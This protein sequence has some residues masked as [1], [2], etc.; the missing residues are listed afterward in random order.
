MDR[1][2]ALQ[3]GGG[4]ATVLR[5]RAGQCGR[6]HVDHDAGPVGIDVRR[7]V[8][9]GEPGERVGEMALVRLGR[10]GG[11]VLTELAGDALQRGRH[12]RALRRRQPACQAEALGPLPPHAQVAAP[13]LPLCLV[14]AH[15]PGAPGLGLQEGRRATLG[16]GGQLG[17]GL[18]VGDFGQR[19]D[20]V[21]GEAA[22]GIG[23]GALGQPVEGVGD[24]DP[25]AG[26]GEPEAE[27]GAE[28]GGHVR[29][30]VVAE[31]PAAVELANQ[32]EQLAVDG[33]HAGGELADR[34][35]QLDVGT[36]GE[37]ERRL[38]HGEHLFRRYLQLATR[39]ISYLHRMN[40]PVGWSCCVRHRPGAVERGLSP[41][42]SA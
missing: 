4:P 30:A 6:V 20:L 28:P 18:L 40:E 36:V 13:V 38:R 9:G 31:G 37:G 23:A 8:A 39:S 12:H 11:P 32:G 1:V 41:P 15:A 22:L 26:V 14:M 16:G 42:A 7:Q 21:P 33:R 2:A 19:P 3:L 34:V 5:P 27:A 17:V 35:G 25:L 10:I 24:P 29:G